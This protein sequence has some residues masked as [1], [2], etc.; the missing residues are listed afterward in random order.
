ARAVLDLA[1]RSGTT[2]M[3]S[4]VE[5]DPIV[6]LKGL[7]ALL[8]LKREYAAAVDLQLCAFAQEGILQAPGT[9]ELLAQAL[10][11]GADLAGGVPYNDRDAP[12]QIDIVSQLARRFGVDADFHADFSDEPEHLHVRDICRETIRHGWQGRVAVGHASELGA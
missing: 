8:P 11:S 1:V 5:V 2:A 6:G 7:H 3:R 10:A 12:A 9:E 4:H